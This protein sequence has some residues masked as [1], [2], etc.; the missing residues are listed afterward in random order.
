MRLLDRITTLLKADA[1]AVVESLEERS[2][3]LQQHLR[4]AELA[5]DH[6]RARLETLREDERRLADALGRLEEEAGA[7]DA[8]VTLAL[9]GGKE[10]LARFA[11][12]RL[13]ARRREIDTVRAELAARRTEGGALA[14][15][16][17]V[18]AAALEG[19]RVRV[20]GE[21]A[22]RTREAE[23]PVWSREEAVADEEVELEL[24]RRRQAEGG[25]A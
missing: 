9:G 13:L 18:Q 8:D 4:E 25:G 1:H 20:R 5:L 23:A 10:E 11:A 16:L 24:L 22:R 21:L 7:L 14:E 15:R 17:E 19:M 12:R 2:L 6:K 3:L